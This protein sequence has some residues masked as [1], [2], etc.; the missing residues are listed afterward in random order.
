M[1]I[2][3]ETSSLNWSDLIS[4]FVGICAL[5]T[6]IV[7]I[8]LT[9]KISRNSVKPLISTISRS[10]EKQCGMKMKNYGNAPAVITKIQFTNKATNLVFNGFPKAFPIPSEYWEN[11]IYF[12]ADKYYLSAGEEI[13]LGII[14]KQHLAKAPKKKSYLDMKKE[15]DIFKQNVSTYIEYEDVYG[16]K[17]PPY[18]RASIISLTN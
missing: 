17:M 15:Y 9:R 5:I 11:Y 3:I 4:L 14:D 16:N 18:Y 7:S 8:L 6:A 10:G 2:P 1:T 12:T 13:I